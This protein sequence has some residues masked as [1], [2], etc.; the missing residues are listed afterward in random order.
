MA[1]VYD[2]GTH[3]VM[4]QKLSLNTLKSISDLKE[5]HRN[6]W[7]PTTLGCWFSDSIKRGGI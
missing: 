5:H 4:N 1:T 2:S 6:H 7:S 3:Y